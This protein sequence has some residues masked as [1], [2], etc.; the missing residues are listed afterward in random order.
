MH[1]TRRSST[2]QVCIIALLLLLYLIREYPIEWITRHLQ[3]SSLRVV[4]TKSYSILHSEESLLRQI[5]VA[6]QK[7]PLMSEELRNS[8]RR[9]IDVVKQR[10]RN[11]CR[12]ASNNRIP[13]SFDYCI[14][15]E[16]I[17]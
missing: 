7:L 17:S 10:V 1:I 6:E 2:L 13:L 15:A 9:E 4:H 11:M 14:V 5:N 3:K 8:M 12:E 16:L